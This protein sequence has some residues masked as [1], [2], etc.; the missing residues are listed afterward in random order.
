MLNVR[1]GVLA[2][3]LHLPARQWTGALLDLAV[4]VIVKGLDFHVLDPP[5]LDE[6]LREPSDRLRRAAGGHVKPS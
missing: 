4:H 3:D 5:E 6:V 1:S 2:E